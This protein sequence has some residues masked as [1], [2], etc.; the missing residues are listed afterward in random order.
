MDCH[1]SATSADSRN[2]W[3]FFAIP[4]PVLKIPLKTFIANPFVK[5]YYESLVRKSRI[6]DFL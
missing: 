1:E 2:D 3:E 5:K 4:P 6:I